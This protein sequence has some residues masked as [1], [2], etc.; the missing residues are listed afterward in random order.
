MAVAHHNYAMSSRYQNP[1]A[2]HREF[3]TALVFYDLCFN[4]IQDAW[5]DDEDFLLLLLAVW[6]NMGHIHAHR[7]NYLE[8][9]EMLSSLKEILEVVS[10]SPLMQ[11]Q[12]VLFF[13]RNLAV[14]EEQEFAAAPAA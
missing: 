12:D 14:Y 2:A 7:Y 13:Y 11:N 1:I 10:S 6:N 9:Q 4:R 8:T 3:R 5:V